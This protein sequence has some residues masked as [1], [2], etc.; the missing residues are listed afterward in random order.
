VVVSFECVITKLVSLVLA[1]MYMVANSVAAS[2]VVGV[3]VIWLDSVTNGLNT[4]VVVTLFVNVTLE[5]LR[6][7]PCRALFAD[8]ASFRHHSRISGQKSSGARSANFRTPCRLYK[9][10]INNGK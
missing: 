7:T 8:R 2:E 6:L 3:N 1:L 9:I 5:T 10:W 4:V